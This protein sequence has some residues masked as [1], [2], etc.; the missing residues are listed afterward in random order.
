MLWCKD[1]PELTTWSKDIF[2]VP[3]HDRD[4]NSVMEYLFLET[5]KSNSFKLFFKK[6]RRRKKKTLISSSSEIIC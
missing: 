3:V 5:N 1:G 2:V 4:K 6:K